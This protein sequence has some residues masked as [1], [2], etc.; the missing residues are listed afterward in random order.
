[1]LIWFEGTVKGWWRELAELSVVKWWPSTCNCYLLKNKQR[2]SNQDLQFAIIS[3]A[4][5][6]IFLSSSALK[7]SGHQHVC[8]QEKSIKESCELNSISRQIQH[9][10]RLPL[11]HARCN[12]MWKMCGL[13][14]APWIHT[15]VNCGQLFDQTTDLKWVCFEMFNIAAFQGSF[16]VKGGE[17]KTIVGNDV[18]RI[19]VMAI[20][21]YEA[22][23]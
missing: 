13:T 1:M 11:A 2:S 18:F 20:K 16:E 9:V 22:M 6:H 5:F 12:K 17:L 10:S 3:G 7:G 19:V 15:T 8:Q 14:D 21:V 4:W 23:L